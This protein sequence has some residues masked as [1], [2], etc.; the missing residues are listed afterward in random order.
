MNT[1]LLAAVA[2]IARSTAGEYLAGWAEGRTRYQLAGD[3]SVIAPSRFP[4]RSAARAAS[5]AAVAF[6]ATLDDA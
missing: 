2:G 4:R 5:Q 3:K 6:Y 1:R